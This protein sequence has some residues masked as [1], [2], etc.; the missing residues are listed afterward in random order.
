MNNLG[1]NSFKALAIY[2]FLNEFNCLENI[3]KNKF[4]NIIKETS[5]QDK[6]RL[7]FYRGGLAGRV[8]IDYTKEL[9]KYDECEFKENEEFKSF[10]LNHVIKILQNSNLNKHFPEKINF[11]AKKNNQINFFDGIKCFISMRNKLAHE[12]ENLNFKNSDYFELLPI[13]EI[14]KVLEFDYDSNI[15]DDSQIQII[16]SNVVFIKQIISCISK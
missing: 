16:Y 13:E 3:I 10:T 8:V 14:R 15:D 5:P 9:I 4:V 1:K 7:Y 11:I 2:N 6:N 12:L